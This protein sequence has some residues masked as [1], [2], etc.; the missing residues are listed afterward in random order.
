KDG[1]VK[2]RG[3][4][5]ETAEVEVAILEF[6]NVQEVAVIHIGETDETRVLISFVASQR[7]FTGNELR[8][9]LA[10]RLPDY[11]VPATIIVLEE[12]P[13]NSTGKIA[14]ALLREM[15]VA[16]SKTSIDAQQAESQSRPESEK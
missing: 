12:L 15:A 9:Q 10:T 14:R 1:Q 6:P 5:V 2:I 13:H 7:A 11:M 8:S 4:R 16:L 3:N